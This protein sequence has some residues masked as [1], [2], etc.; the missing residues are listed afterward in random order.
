MNIPSLSNLIHWLAGS[1]A[2]SLSHSVRTSIICQ[3]NATKKSVASFS[4]HFPKSVASFSA[5]WLRSWLRQFDATPSVF[6]PSVCERQFDLINIF[7]W[8]ETKNVSGIYRTFHN[9]DR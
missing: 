7:C 1:L 5:K 4:S 3:Q 8:Y 2:N 6:K 9:K